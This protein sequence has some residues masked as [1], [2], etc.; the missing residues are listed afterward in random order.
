MKCYRCC[1]AWN[2]IRRLFGLKRKLCAGWTVEKAVDLK[3][4][5]G[6]D[7]E[8]ELADILKEEI[9]KEMILE[10]GPDW[11]KEQDEQIIKCLKEFAAEKEK[12]NE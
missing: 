5:H 12:K 1:K 6:F 11:Q 4:M 7:V 8:Q 10:Y 9:N 3:A 2:F